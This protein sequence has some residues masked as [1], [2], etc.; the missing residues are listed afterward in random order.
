MNIFTD[1]NYYANQ[2]WVATRYLESLTLL[3]GIFP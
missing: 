2:L 1:Y 3:I